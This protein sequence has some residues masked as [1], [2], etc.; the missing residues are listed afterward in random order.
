MTRFEQVCQKLYE[1][2]QQH[3]NQQR[4]QFQAQKQHADHWLKTFT[5]EIKNLNHIRYFLEN[6]QSKYV[7]FVAASALKQ[8]FSENLSDI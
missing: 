2:P 5:E 3:S 8:L 7:Q 1:N 4:Q 6:S